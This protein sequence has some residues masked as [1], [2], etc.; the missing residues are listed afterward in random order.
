[1]KNSKD[2]KTQDSA[3]YYCIFYLVMTVLFHVFLPVVPAL[4]FLAIT[5]AHTPYFFIL[6]IMLLLEADFVSP[7]RMLGG[8]VIA[9]ELLIGAALIVVSVIAFWKKK[10]YPFWMLSVFSNIFTICAIILAFCLNG[11]AVVLPAFM[12]C[13]IL[14]NAIFGYL[15]YRKINKSKECPKA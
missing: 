12:L 10:Y 8:T 9:G 6:I 13:S 5:G 1:M 4:P 11:D 3:K 2:A 15:L 14:G 7:G